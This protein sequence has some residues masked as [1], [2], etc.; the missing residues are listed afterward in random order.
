MPDT[1]RMT[2]LL[3]FPFHSFLMLR[4]EYVLLTD[5]ND[6]EAKILRIIEKRMDDQRKQLYQEEINALPAGLLPH[7]P[8]LDI[9]K[10]VWVAIS[11]ASFLYDLY[12]LVQSE[13][14]LKKALMSLVKKRF[15]LTRKGQGRYAP[16]E[17]QLNLQL[18][19]EE[20]SKMG[21]Q[22]KAGYQPLI[23]SADGTLTE[24]AGYQSLPP[25][26]DQPVIPSAAA[27]VSVAEPLRGAEVDPSR[28]STTEE[29]R[30][31]TAA[32][33]GRA[34]PSEACAC[35]AAA[36]DSSDPGTLS[37][38]E[39]ALVLAHRRQHISSQ[40]EPETETTPEPD[41]APPDESVT[42]HLGGR[43]PEPLAAVPSSNES[44]FPQGEYE[45]QPPAGTDVP[46]A[47]EK[48][49]T[50][51]KS[52]IGAPLP[53]HCEHA[54][55]LHTDAPQTAPAS[56]GVTAFSDG[57]SAPAPDYTLFAE[58]LST[59]ALVAWME[60]KRGMPYDAQER[61]HQLAAARMLLDLNLPLDLVTLER[62]YDATYD[63]WWKQHF[64]ELH[65]THMVEREKAGTLR[66]TRWLARLQAPA[67]SSTPS[68]S[69]ATSRPPRPTVAPL[70]VRIV[71]RAGPGMRL[72]DARALRE[73]IAHDRRL[74][75]QCQL[76]IV[77]LSDRSYAVLVDKTVTETIRQVA[78]YSLAEWRARSV[79]FATVQ[80]L[81]GIRGR[82]AVS[83]A[84]MMQQMRAESR[85]VVQV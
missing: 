11:H 62:V 30:R 76:A 16:V 31:E 7:T 42:P 3:S 74:A 84:E 41:T 25:S 70:E 78:F 36:A 34:L 19:E 20:L 59:E 28:R 75:G 85:K 52:L 17:Y 58:A 55:R 45:G 15:I 46:D 49:A 68:A 81:F 69:T 4:L 66:I 72:S 67:C 71:L 32:E 44:R 35:N 65:L 64:G 47:P 38:A 9:L 48:F 83:I 51:T 2:P 1:E 39:I 33:E 79:T 29:E 57:M 14:T 40:S 82:P 50:A 27:R 13:N 63:D 43:S 56:S 37:S 77:T 21:R 23:P 80:E 26:E 53:D 22:G 18:I 6:L 24:P 73:E 61:S 5:G 10:A 12:G 8:V 60:R 54:E